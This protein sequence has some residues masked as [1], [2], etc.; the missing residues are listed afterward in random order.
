MMTRWFSL[1][2]LCTAL[3]AGSLHAAESA[4]EGLTPQM[5]LIQARSM[6]P[7]EHID[8]TGTLETAEARG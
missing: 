4:I 6:F 8:V 7:Q 2:I 3:L 1:L 5:M